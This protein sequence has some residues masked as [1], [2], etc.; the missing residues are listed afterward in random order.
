MTNLTLKAREVFANDRYATDIT[1]VTLDMVEPRHVC[2]SLTITPSHRN[3]MEA[4]MGGVMFTLADLAFAA[5]ANADVLESG[6]NLAWVSVG[7]EIHFLA[8]PKGARLLA[9]ASCVKQ[10]RTTCVFS[11]SIKDELNTPVAMVTTTGMKTN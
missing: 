11:I 8:Q 3:A 10:G 7:S 2:C 4:V 9:E 6:G 1:G 5:A